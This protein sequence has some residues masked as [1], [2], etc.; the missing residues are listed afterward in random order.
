MARAKK[1]L[2]I[3]GIIVA[4]I[5]LILIITP[6]F[7]NADQF[8]PQIEAA[9]SEK[10]GRK[11]QLG[12]VSV[13]LI[14]G[15]LSA[16]QISIADD[17]SFSHEPFLTAKSL[18]VGVDVVPL[19]F[20]RD[21][22]VH[23]LNFNDPHVQLLRTAA[24]QW[25]FATL[26]SPAP[27]HGAA[28]PPRDASLLPVSFV[29]TPANTSS[30]PALNSFSVEKMKISD[31][32]IAFGRAG[33]P[34]RLAYQDVNL[35]A[36]NISQ[37]AAFPFQFDAKTPNGGKI[38]LNGNL[39]P[40]GNNDGSH[41]PFEGRTKAENVPAQDVQNL[42]AVLGYA[43]PQ[44]SNLKGGTINSDLTLHG[45]LDRFVAEGPVKLSGVTLAGFS[46]A[47]KLAT[48]LGQA[49]AQPAGQMGNDTLIKVAQGALRYG[50]QGINADGLN[51]Q[52]AFVGSVI[53][54]GTISAS[55]VLN[56]RLLAKLDGS[57]PL[58]QL[59]Q[60]PIF[61]KGGGIPF[62]VQ[63]TASNPQITADVPGL[64]KTPLNQLKI[65]QTGKLGG[66]LGGLLN[67]KKKPQ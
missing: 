11:V 63:G 56:F 42:L 20:S 64:S 59:T 52:I 44:G 15:S 35:S 43:I 50:P 57:S 4:V 61:N 66:M 8:R 12:H 51:V 29:V 10:L 54:A 30:S 65:P 37:T 17:P 60:L 49:G 9:L 24:G 40:V 33:E 28:S 53:G 6:F 27:S 1:P 14:S 58:A 23:S 38:T 36:Q 25:N 13:S 41:I 67:K 55:N 26:A 16:N 31:G 62:R 48:A 3:I 47:S 45:P 21:L 46:V 19:I 32:R 18:N 7:I 34:T 22:R 2:I 39:G 5:L